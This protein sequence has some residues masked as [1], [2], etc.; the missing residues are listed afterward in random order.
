MHTVDLSPAFTVQGKFFFRSDRKFFLKAM[1]LK[2]VQPPRD[3]SEKLALRDRLLKLTEAHTTGLVVKEADAEAVADLA[4]QVG[5]C[6]VVEAG[7]A[8]ETLFD[9]GGLRGLKWNSNAPC[10]R[11]R[12]VRS[13]R[14]T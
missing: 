6:L 3:F 14:D 9:R 11:W 7:I 5:M 2:G 1:R 13:S 8:P 12:A 10:A 4:G